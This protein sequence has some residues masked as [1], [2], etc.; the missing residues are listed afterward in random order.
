VAGQDDFF[1][2]FG[3]IPHGVSRPAGTVRSYFPWYHVLGQY[4]MTCLL[5]GLGIGGMLLFLVTFPFPV[6]AV[7]ATVPLAGFGALVYFANR[8]DYLWVELDGDT[9]RARHLY[10]GRVIERSVGEIEDL[11]TVVF[12]HRSAVEVAIVEAWLGRIRGIKIRFR[13]GRTPLFVSRTDPAMK[14]AKEL[15]EAVAYRMSAAGE[16]DAEMIDFEGTP[17]IQR[18]HWK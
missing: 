10:T 9:L 7:V 16:V 5:S 17:M 11:L 4:V 1:R 12:L 13:D 2:D 14:N 8:N 3:V 15:I 6:N 18:I